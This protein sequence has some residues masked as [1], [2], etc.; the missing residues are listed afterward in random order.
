MH[1][2]ALRRRI[3]VVAVTTRVAAR[4]LSGDPA[5]ADQAVRRGLVLLDGIEA[6]LGPDS[7]EIRATLAELRGEFQSLLLDD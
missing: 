3:R 1:A 6:D 7:R 4:S 2:E 5:Q